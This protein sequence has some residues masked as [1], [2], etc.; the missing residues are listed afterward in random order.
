MQISTALAF[1]V[2]VICS[3]FADATKAKVQRNLGIPVYDAEYE[4]DAQQP[5]YIQQPVTGQQFTY[6]QQARDVSGLS[7]QEPS[8]S[9]VVT[10]AYEQPAQA[11]SQQQRR[12]ANGIQGFTQSSFL[13]TPAETSSAEAMSELTKVVQQQNQ[14]MMVLQ[15]ENH[16]L[17]RFNKQFADK[18]LSLL[19]RLRLSSV[20]RCDTYYPN[21]VKD[22]A[23]CGTACTAADKNFE[24][25]DF[26]ENQ[27]GGLVGASSLTH[28]SYRC[29]CSTK[30]GTVTPICTDGARAMGISMLATLGVLVLLRHM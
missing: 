11:F 10:S 27:W 22:D 29:E 21:A 28:K 15:E 19:E 2:A 4:D 3:S 23:S 1:M 20:P 16:E 6:D 7:Q 18:T 9:F 13:G 17:A 30:E 5:A 8:A 14:A 24:S 12:D 25:S 26:Q